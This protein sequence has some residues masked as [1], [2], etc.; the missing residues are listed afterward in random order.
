MKTWNH[1]QKMTGKIITLGVAGAALSLGEL[2]AAS[3]HWTAY[4][5]PGYTYTPSGNFTDTNNW[6]TQVVPT[7][8]DD[9]LFS[10]AG[11]TNT[12]NFSQSQTVN[13]VQ[14]YNYNYTIFNL[15]GFTF[16]TGASGF[17]D[18]Y[19]SGSGGPPAT[20]EVTG[21]GLWDMPFHLRIGEFSYVA[22]LIIDSGSAVR[23]GHLSVSPSATAST[24][25]TLL[26][27]N[28]GTF[29]MTTTSS[30]TLGSPNNH[31]ATVA[32]AGLLTGDDP[33]LHVSELDS[34]GTISPGDAG[35][36]TLTFQDVYL[37][38][39]GGTKLKMEIGGTAPSQYDR[40]EFTKVL[41]ANQSVLDLGNNAATLDVTFLNSF[42]GQ[43]ND[44]FDLVVAPSGKIIN[45]SGLSLSVNPAGNGYYGYLSIVAEDA[46]HDALRLTLTYVPEPSLVAF[47]TLGGLLLLRKKP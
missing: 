12:V 2:Y 23:A 16:A 9:L 34:Y 29:G 24:P 21:G 28:G 30:H 37:Y 43:T 36:G 38:N 31:D 40:L 18:I 19:N 35:I 1:I 6:T 42:V 44:F 39:V 13:S 11:V 41:S 22:N 10:D 5:P 45:T 8:A 33:T 27:K 4:P 20:V 17:N 32:G 7:S 3:T 14:V 15:N 26:I 47:L 46:T 25:S